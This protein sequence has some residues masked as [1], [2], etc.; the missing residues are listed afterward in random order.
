M[1]TEGLPQKLEGSS[2]L[3]RI[4]E[5]DPTRRAYISMTTDA[6]YWVTVQKERILTSAFTMLAIHCHEYEYNNIR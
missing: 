3:G 2:H 1:K 5:E 6:N 4:T